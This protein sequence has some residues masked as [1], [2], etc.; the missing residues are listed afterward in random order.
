MFP[1]TQ[2]AIK[3]PQASDFHRARVP[4]KKPKITK[5]HHHTQQRI[6]DATTGGGGSAAAAISPRFHVAEMS[7]DCLRIRLLKRRASNSFAHFQG[8]K[9]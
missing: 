1:F 5:H 7:A 9:L 3:R 2:M 6:D 4:H 8:G